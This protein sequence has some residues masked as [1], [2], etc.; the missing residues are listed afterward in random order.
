MDY[1]L[2]VN[3][4]KYKESEKNSPLENYLTELFAY[5]LRM[6]IYQQE[7][8]VITLINDYFHIPFCKD[9]LKNT[10]IETQKEYWIEKH[11]VYA[12]PDL[13]IKINKKNIYFIENKV[14]SES[15]Y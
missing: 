12:R 5:I 3:L 1:D 9:D 6:L 13:I 8:S 4:F 7:P 14:D 10:I 15:P 2:F 11:Q